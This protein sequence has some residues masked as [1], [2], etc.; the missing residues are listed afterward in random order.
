MRKVLLAAFLLSFS[1]FGNSENLNESKPLEKKV[2]RIYSAGP[3][4]FLASIETVSQINREKKAIVDKINSQLI[5]QKAGFTFDVILLVEGSE[6]PDIKQDIETGVKIY[7]KNI[8]LMNSAD[9]II[10][11][12]VKFRGLHADPGTVFE[13]GYMEGQGKPVIPFYNENHFYWEGH[14]KPP[15]SVLDRVLDEGQYT[16]KINEK[17]GVKEV[18]DENDHLA[19]NFNMTENAMVV[20]SFIKLMREASLNDKMP[21]SFEDAVLRTVAFLKFKRSAG[22]RSAF[23][24]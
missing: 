22:C 14:V 1:F 8:K 17:T 9:I 20:A 6:V 5:E 10:A 18:F 11:N 13:M 12:I 2:Y 16:I 19:E 3:E 7:E 24:P 23:I 15:T 4:V 21:E